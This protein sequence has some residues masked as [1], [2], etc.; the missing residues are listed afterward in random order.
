MECVLSIRTG[1]V[2]DRYDPKK[3]KTLITKIIE[4]EDF[5]LNAEGIALHSPGYEYFCALEI[6][7]HFLATTSYK[8]PIAYHKP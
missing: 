7:D 3:Q 1:R 4:V 2:R 5:T 6:F 8:L